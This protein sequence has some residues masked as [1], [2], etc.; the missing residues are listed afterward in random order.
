LK[1]KKKRKESLST[2]VNRYK[3][4]EREICERIDELK[5]FGSECNCRDTK[6]F[7]MVFHG[8]D[9]EILCYCLKCGGVS[10]V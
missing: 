5:N 10:D 7:T 9:D 8:G 4:I 1:M 2:L 6:K 3:R